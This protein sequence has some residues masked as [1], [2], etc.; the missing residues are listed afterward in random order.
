MEFELTIQ[1]RRQPQVVF[2]FLAN[3]DRVQQDPRSSV[4]ALERLTPGPTAMG[5]R[6]REVVLVLPFLQGE[7]LSEVTRCEAPTVLEE[8][9]A[10]AGM[11]GHLSYLFEPVQDGTRLVQRQ[12]LEARGP[13]K[14]LHPLI[15]LLL[16]CRLHDRLQE[17]KRLLEADARGRPRSA[18]R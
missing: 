16:G 3:K 13:L 7:I 17:I 12:S 1:I 2:E 14:L 6:F 9:Y 4:L 10:G 8:A 11:S 18:Q 5:T 15:R